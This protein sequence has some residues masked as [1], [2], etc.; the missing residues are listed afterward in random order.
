ME[1][2]PPDG[3]PLEATRPDEDAE[4]GSRPTT[5]PAVARYREDAEG[6]VRAYLPSPC[7][8]ERREHGPAALSEARRL[9]LNHGEA[10]AP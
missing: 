10:R 8:P 7:T 6:A 1:E 2:T 4:G 9:G 3:F 5:F